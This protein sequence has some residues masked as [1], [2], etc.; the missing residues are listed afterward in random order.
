MASG[1]APETVSA[2]LAKANAYIDR[3]EARG[4]ACH[5][6]A[7]VYARAISG[8]WDVPAA[9]R[10]PSKAPAGHD[11]RVPPDGRERER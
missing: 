3:L 7:A 10:D 5:D 6:P 1:L 8:R 2:C 4:Q 11:G 9:K